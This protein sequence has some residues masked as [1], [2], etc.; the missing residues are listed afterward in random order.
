MVAYTRKLDAG[1]RPFLPCDWLLTVDLDG[2]AR[3]YFHFW[4]RGLFYRR[5]DA[6]L[7]QMALESLSAD[8]FLRTRREDPPEFTP[9]YSYSATLTNDAFG[10]ACWNLVQLDVA[11]RF[12]LL[13]E[14][15][16]R[17]ASFAVATSRPVPHVLRQY[18]HDLS[19]MRP[20]RFERLANGRRF[21]PRILA[22]FIL[23]KLPG[24]AE[25]EP[26]LFPI[27][28]LEAPDDDSVVI[29]DVLS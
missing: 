26:D 29:G 8:Y 18:F 28:V 17:L 1:L 7:N 14:R 13:V 15:P 12:L 24:V 25:T 27:P 21:Q 5:Q 19:S 4:R 22:R 23:P 10:P 11:A 20:R 16:R 3:V 9:K 2:I 6:R